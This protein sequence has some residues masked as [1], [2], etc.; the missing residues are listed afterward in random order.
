MSKICTV[1]WV[2]C[3]WAWIDDK[4]ERQK[5]ESMAATAPPHR[6][7]STVKSLSESPNLSSIPSNYVHVNDPSEAAAS[8]PDGSIPTVDLSL[9]TSDDPERKSRAIE[10]LDRA[11]QEWGFFMVVNHGI[12]EE[13]MRGVIEAVKEFFDL[14]EE[15]KPEFEPED[16]L[17][18]IRYGTSFNTAKEEVFCWRDFLKVFV[19]PHFHCPDKPESLRAVLPEYCEQLG[20]VARTL[21]KGISQGLGLDGGLMEAALELESGLQIFAANL[22]PRCPNPDA[23]MGIVSHSDHGL[24]TLLIQNE[25][26]GLQIQHN[27][28]WMNVDP[29]PNSILVNTC[30]Q[31]EVVSN[32]MYKSVL[33]RAVVNNHNTRISVAVVNGPS[34]DAVVQPPMGC[35]PEYIPIKYRDYLLAQQNN[36]LKGKS[37]L[38]Q[39]RI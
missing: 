1:T 28:K 35:K 21:L 16:V 4:A 33:H 27:G 20:G 26:S 8:D 32:G 15:E 13:L 37:I 31:L 7:G 19:H 12:S 24:L 9:L 29:L 14:P 25:V 30:D 23:A 22:Y 2:L 3:F 11:C 36:Q 34:L 5:L 6:R 38:K 39:I 10:D 17:S 18:P